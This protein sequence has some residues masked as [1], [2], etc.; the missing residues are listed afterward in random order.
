MNPGDIFLFYIALG[1]VLLAGVLLVL[2][3]LYK[4]PIKSKK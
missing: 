3:T 2:P 4:G 1:L